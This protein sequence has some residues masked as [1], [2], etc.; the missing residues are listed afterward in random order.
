MGL[1]HLKLDH[2]AVRDVVVPPLFR[3]LLHALEERGIGI[4]L[5]AWFG[6][7][8]SM[9]TFETRHVFARRG[10]PR[11]TILSRRGQH[12]MGRV[13]TIALAHELGHHTAWSR[14]LDDAE[15]TRVATE[16]PERLRAWALS[17]AAAAR[18]V[19]EAEARAWMFAH[20]ELSALGFVDWPLFNRQ[21]AAAF[22]SYA[23]AFRSLATF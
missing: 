8:E 23:R 4:R 22:G 18:A 6:P 12:G 15:Y 5:G 3:H 19:L 13:H 17:S 11:I 9:G 16:E 2:D 7:P 20:A 21:A 14:G 1:D 10:I